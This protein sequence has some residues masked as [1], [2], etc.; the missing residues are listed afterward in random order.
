MYKSI[1]EIQI[2]FNEAGLKHSVEE[3][4]TNWLLRAGVSGNAAQ[5]D[6]LFIKDDDRGNDVAVRIGHVVKYP[7]ERFAKAYETLNSLQVKYRFI[8]FTLDDEGNVNVEYDF[9]T[10][11]TAIGPGAVEI[12]VRLVKILDECYSDLMRSIW[13]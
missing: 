5:Y 6:F 12:L 4:G 7:K 11:Y 10:A 3:I 1:E 13:A 8:R 2:A 9:P